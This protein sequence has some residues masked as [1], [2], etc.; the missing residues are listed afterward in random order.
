VAEGAV[1]FSDV[2]LS[3]VGDDEIGSGQKWEQFLS[4]RWEF[5]RVLNMFMRD[6]VDF[7]EVLTEPAMTPWRTNQPVAGFDQLPVLKHRNASRANTSV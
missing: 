2:K 7:D 3:V 4:N 5:W 1:E 6:A